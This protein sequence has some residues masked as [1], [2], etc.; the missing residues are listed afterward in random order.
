MAVPEFYSGKL[1]YPAIAVLI[2]LSALF[3]IAIRPRLSLQNS[4]MIGQPA[5]PL[6]L[7]VAANGT[8]GTQMS[9]ADLKGRPIL[10][11]FWASWCGPCAM[12]APIVD[13]VARRYGK[14]GLAVVGVNVSDTA[15]T[16]RTYAAQKGLSYPMVLDPNSGASNRYG[17]HQLPSLIVI[18]KAGHRDRLPDRAGR[19]GLSERPR[20]NRDVGG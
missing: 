15:D 1:L 10:L 19:R 8:A 17:V 16:V 14:K 9:L 13:R 6:S 20:R 5:P 12:E 18:D 2:G 11:D 3:G 4:G 7:P